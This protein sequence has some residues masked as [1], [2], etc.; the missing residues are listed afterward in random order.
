M[1]Q[2]HKH[3][4]FSLDDQSFRE[5]QELA[6][7]QRISLSSLLRLWIKDAYRATEG[8]TTSG[9]NMGPVF[10]KLVSDAR[11]KIKS[12]HSTEE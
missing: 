9:I 10:L 12:K 4:G 8:E 3:H 5:L 11:R 1:A 7:Q 6:E 2:T